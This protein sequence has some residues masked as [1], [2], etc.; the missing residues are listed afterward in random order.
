VN[1][2]IRN[3]VAFVGLGLLSVTAAYS[4]YFQEAI[5]AQPQSF[6]HTQQLLLP[7]MQVLLPDTDEPR[8]AVL[9]FHGCGGPRDYSVARARR[10]VELGY[11]AILVDS[12][13][14]RGIDWQLS[15][16]GRVLPGSQRAADVLVALEFA[17]QQPAV[18]PDRLFVMGYSHGGWTVL[19]ALANGDALPPKLSDSPGNHLAGVVGVIAWYPYCGIGAEYTRGWSSDVPVLILLAADDQTTAPEP[20]IDIAN[21][22]SQRGLPV[23][24]RV[25]PGVDHGFDLQEDWVKVYDPEIHRQA[26]Q[27][28]NDFLSEHSD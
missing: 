27:L 3:I 19:E 17:R 4:W 11:V 7:Q 26:M 15:C 6:E 14:G 5:F 25:Y 13:T 8:P 10:I 16:E 12:Y 24:W 1:K 21:E 23:Q 22:H 2:W 20:C 9:F 18:D 28:Q